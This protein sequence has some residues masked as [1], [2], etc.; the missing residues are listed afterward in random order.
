[1]KLTASGVTNCAAIVRSPSFSRSS[2]STTT[3]KRP[4]RISSIASSILANGLVSRSV[5]ALIAPS[6][7]RSPRRHEPLDVLRE[8]VDLE[9]HGTA[10]DKLAERRGRERVRDER[11][12]EGVLE[13]LGDGQGDSVDRDRPLLDAEA[14]DLRRRFDNDAQALAFRLD[15]ADAADRVDMALD[16]VPAQR[17]TRP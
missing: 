5:T 1:M 2:S 3:T 11:D 6:Y 7:P 15:G 10:G 9:V 13:Q 16:D 8:D 12:R 4:A 17:L 14:E